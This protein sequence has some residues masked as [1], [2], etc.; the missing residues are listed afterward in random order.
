MEILQPLDSRST[1][2]TCMVKKVKRTRELISWNK[3]DSG[4]RGR[5]MN[6]QFFLLLYNHQYEKNKDSLV[7]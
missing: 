5:L 6:D 2:V 7:I 3:N 4:P 1:S